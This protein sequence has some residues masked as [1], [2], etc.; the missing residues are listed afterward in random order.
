MNFHCY[1]TKLNLTVSSILFTLFMPEPYASYRY[2]AQ[3]QISMI[4]PALQLGQIQVNMNIQ[5]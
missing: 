1:P 2:N 5:Q 3:S 4:N